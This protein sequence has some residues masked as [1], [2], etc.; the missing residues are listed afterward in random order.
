MHSKEVYE[1]TTMSDL[2]A[3]CVFNHVLHEILVAEAGR[4]IG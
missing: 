2:P 1:K 3:L 4:K